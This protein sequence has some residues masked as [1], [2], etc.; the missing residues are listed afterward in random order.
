[1]DFFFFVD[2]LSGGLAVIHLRCLVLT[3][4]PSVKLSKI[5]VEYLLLTLLL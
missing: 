5:E 2:F 1:M 4:R 3:S